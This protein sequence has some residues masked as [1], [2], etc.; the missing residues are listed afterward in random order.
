MK[1]Q[2]IFIVPALFAWST[3]G[4]AQGADANSVLGRDAAQSNAPVRD[5]ARKAPVLRAEANDAQVAFEGEVQIGAVQIGGLEG[6]SPA[7]FADISESYVGRSVDAAALQALARAIADRA[8]SRGYVFASAAIPAQ[9]LRMGIV[10]VVVDE[11][12]VDEVRIAGSDNARLRRVLGKLTGGK[13]R[14]A[15]LE[16][17]LLL[18]GDIPGIV[19]TGT[20]FVREGE[21]G[22]LIVEARD[23]RARGSLT[24]DNWGP[25]AFGPLRARLE[26]ELDG[27]LTSG[28]QFV[29]Y[30]TATVAQPRELTYLSL[31][32]TTHLTD[33]GVQLSLTGGAGRSFE[34]DA[35]TAFE[36]RG[37]SRTAGLGLTAPVLRSSD[38]SLWLSAEG[39]YQQV[40]QD[41]DL[42]PRQRDDIVTASLSGWGSIKLAAGRLAGGV[43]ITRGLGILGATR[44]GDPAASRPDA[45]GGFTKGNAWLNWQGKIAGPVSMRLA[46]NGQ[47]ASRPLL[48]AQEIGLGGPFFGRGYDFSERFGDQGVMGLAELRG[49]FDG[50]KGVLDW[51]QLY[52]FIDGGYVDNLRGGFGG[53]SLVSGGGGIRAGRGRAEF[54]LEVAAPINADRFESGD[55]SPKLNVV[56]S[57]GF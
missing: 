36:A 19:I 17:Q 26:T 57:Y 24:I 53:G 33:T 54:G 14:K 37:R 2:V 25:A 47:V 32:Y 35:A 5:P 49:N 48:A 1:T 39:N 29:T 11:G 6:L 3:A 55:R 44:D 41:F 52:G 40:I 38:A 23:D 34:E 20:R 4:G 56:V 22:V 10:Q 50:P 8:R 27:L 43:S 13:L 31:R 45:S 7:D 15:L 16:R 9:Q 30:T 12:G 46:A 18:A 21:N 51:A 42:G 28:D